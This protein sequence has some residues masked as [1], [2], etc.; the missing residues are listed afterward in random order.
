MV[1]WIPNRLTE[2]S[3]F[4]AYS[5]TPPVSL[6]LH[7]SFPPFILAFLV[8]TAV[9]DQTVL[10]VEWTCYKDIHKLTLV[11]LVEQKLQGTKQVC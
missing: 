7:L 11:T 8:K 9:T 6:F 4:T 3:V 1:L 10:Y 5:Q 2:I